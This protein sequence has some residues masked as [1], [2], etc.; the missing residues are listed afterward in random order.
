V[1]SQQNT[2]VA[3]DKNMK[4]KAEE[5]KVVCINN[6]DEFELERPRSYSLPNLN[7]N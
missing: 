7:Y 1:S 3:E 5:K 6:I 2:N 4:S